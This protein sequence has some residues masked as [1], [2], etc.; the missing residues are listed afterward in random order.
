MKNR[1]REPGTEQDV[2]PESGSV[3]DY[4]VCVDPSQASLVF[5]YLRGAHQD[6][7]VEVLAHL[8]LCLR[9]RAAAATVLKLSACLEGTNHYRPGVTD[10]G[11]L[12]ARD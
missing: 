11:E 8:G 3:Y 7:Q 2:S 9:C 4:Y 6:E 5:D 1:E 10:E 12:A